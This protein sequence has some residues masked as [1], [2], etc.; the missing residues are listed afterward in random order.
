MTERALVAPE[1][2]VRFGLS[3]E[4]FQSWWNRALMPEDADEFVHLRG[5]NKAGARLVCALDYLTATGQERPP[6]DVIVRAY[7]LARKLPE[8]SLADETVRIE[9]AYL[10]QDDAVQSLLDKLR[11]RERSV[12]ME[13]VSKLTLK[14]VEEQLQG[15]DEI[16]EAMKAGVSLMAIDQRAKEAE[17]KRRDNKAYRDALA[18]SR[19]NL[20]DSTQPPS[21]EEALHSIV[22][23]RELFGE[24]ALREMITAALPIDGA[25][26]TTAV[27]YD[28]E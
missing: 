15:G 9:A 21:R 10:Y 4:T 6:A 3:D 22:M 7:V 27:T 25:A 28:G 17:A 19:S 23:F 26:D 13:R 24:Q 20:R 2:G 18:M 12:A 1:A 5:G 14:T 8:T 16:K 11:Y